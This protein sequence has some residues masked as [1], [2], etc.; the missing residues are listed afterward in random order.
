MK[1]QRLLKF[2]VKQTNSDVIVHQEGVYFALYKQKEKY[3]NKFATLL[4][5]LQEAKEKMVSA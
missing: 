5:Q 4:F 1:I 3:M 2:D